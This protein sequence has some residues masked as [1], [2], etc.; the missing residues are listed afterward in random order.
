[1]KEERYFYVPNASD[2]TELPE[3]EA[4]HALKVLRLNVGDKIVLIDGKGS[5][6]SA[7]VS[8]VGNK[9]CWYEINEE[10]PQAK[11]WK[12]NIH[13]AIAPTKMMDRM[14]WM[15]EKITE[16]G[17][18]EISF[19]N[20]Q[21]SERK[22]LRIDRLDKIIISAVKQSRKAWLPQIKPMISFND[23]ISLPFNGKKYI[24]HCYNEI[25]RV[26][27]YD[28]MKKITGDESITVLIGPEGD[29]SLAEVNLALKHGFISITLGKS[30][31]RTETAGLFSVT[32]SHLALR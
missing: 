30:R 3:E 9:H 17:V 15:V 10:I 12:G 29:F 18:D 27:F 20:C 19:L 16:I 31:L 25:P 22:L 2:K 21:F 24:A 26:D 5:F 32:L 14:E 7:T 8:M 4:K 28:E 1:M 13:L 11:E 23:F 6:Y